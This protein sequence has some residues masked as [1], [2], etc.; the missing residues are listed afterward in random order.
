MKSKLFWNQRSIVVRKRTLNETRDLSLR[1]LGREWKRL[2]P[3]FFVLGVPIA[4][5]DVVFWQ[6]VI[7]PSSFREASVYSLEKSIYLY[8]LFAFLLWITVLFETAFIGSLTTLYLGKWMFSVDGKIDRRAI[9]RDF[10]DRLPQLFYYLV[11]TR[12]IR[13]RFFYAETILLERLPFLKTD[14][15]PSTRKRVASMNYGGVFF[16][17]WTARFGTELYVI[18]G[19]LTALASLFPLIRY[20]FV[21]WDY[22]FYAL[23]Y[24]LYPILLLC[25]SLYTTVYNFFQYVNYRILYEGWDVELALSVEVEKLSDD[26]TF[27][28]APNASG[29]DGSIL[30]LRTLADAALDHDSNE[31][32]IQETDAD[33]HFQSRRV[34]TLDSEASS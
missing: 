10:A 30:R 17:L 29:R 20:V 8:S 5:L 19:V 9:F 14:A 33:A 26:M 1:V 7:H 32:S 15:L 24:L 31:S 11:L 27:T 23:F 25:G 3:Y 28:S 22:A 4:A 34:E 16:Q 2:V 18:S 6:L 21:E 13:R 12:L